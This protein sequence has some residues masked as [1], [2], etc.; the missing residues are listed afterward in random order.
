MVLR[1]YKAPNVI[2]GV[3]KL[4]E[5]ETDYWTEE[6]SADGHQM[7]ITGYKDKKRTKVRSVQVLDRVK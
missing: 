7:S 3:T 6:V 4:P 5:G 2:E 1:R